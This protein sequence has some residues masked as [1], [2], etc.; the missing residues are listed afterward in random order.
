MWKYTARDIV[1]TALAQSWD[2]NLRYEWV[3]PSLAYKFFNFVQNDIC[4]ELEDLDKDH[5][6]W[7]FF[8]DTVWSQSEYS[9][10]I[11]DSSVFWLSKPKKIEI[12]YTD[13]ANLY[14]TA[15][16]IQKPYFWDEDY[17]SL[18]RSKKEPIAFI[19]W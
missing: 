6:I 13:S 1:E 16:L 19:A 7:E 3:N 8:I 12:K 11:S 14:E 10:P 4:W 5:L 9:L 2:S 15:Q 17:E 18:Y